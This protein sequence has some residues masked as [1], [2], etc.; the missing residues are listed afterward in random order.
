MHNKFYVLFN[1]ITDLE[2][3]IKPIRRP[4]FP[5]LKKIYNEHP[6]DGKDGSEYE[7]LGYEDRILTIE[8]NFIDRKNIYDKVRQITKWLNNI[9]DFKLCLGDDPEYFYI[10][11]KLEYDDITRKFKRV[12]NFKVTF[13]LEPFAYQFS[14]NE[15]FEIK[16]NEVIYNNGDFESKPIIEI[17]GNGYVKL[18]VNENLIELNIADIVTINSKLEL[19]FKNKIIEPARKKGDFPILKMEFNT[20]RWEGNVRRVTI[21][22]NCIYY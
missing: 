22:P 19:C 18:W 5:S 3:G 21:N 16:N 12:G 11:K 17:E 4:N 7:F 10:V 15:N 1:G 9:Q 20:I 14:T 13:T 8:Y 6:V 2:L